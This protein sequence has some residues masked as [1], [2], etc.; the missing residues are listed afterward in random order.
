MADQGREPPTWQ[1][2]NKL[3]KIG[4]AGFIVQ[5]FATGCT[6][7]NR[8][9][10]LWDWSDAPPHRIVVIDDL[11]RLPKSVESWKTDYK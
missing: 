1:L 4:C 9:L 8:N 6:E 10:V 7:E 2:A 3:Q 5:S 11:G